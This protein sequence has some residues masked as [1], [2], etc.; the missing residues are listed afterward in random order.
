MCA[1]SQCVCGTWASRITHHARCKR[2]Y[3]NRPGRI[4]QQPNTHHAQ[5]AVMISAGGPRTCASIL[6]WAD[7][8]AVRCP[9]V[10]FRLKARAFFAMLE[11]ASRTISHG[12]MIL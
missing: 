12:S 1:R 7:S 6:N 10:D 5:R 11:N 4:C 9:R 3:V 8:L 2:A